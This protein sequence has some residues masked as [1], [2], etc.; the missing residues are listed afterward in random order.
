MSEIEFV[1]QVTPMSGREA[2]ERFGGDYP[3][4]RRVLVTE[5]YE[6]TQ[7]GEPVHSLHVAS[8]TRLTFR[9]R[10]IDVEV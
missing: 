1:E 3:W 10:T 2:S 6:P 8:G 9:S 5:R 4:G 7:R